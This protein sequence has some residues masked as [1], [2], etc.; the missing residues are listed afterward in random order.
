MKR[1]IPLIFPLFLLLF[2]EVS[3][4]NSWVSNSMSAPATSVISKTYSLIVN[5]YPEPEVGGAFIPKVVRS[6]YRLSAG[7]IIGMILGTTFAFIN[8]SSKITNR[9]INPTLSFLAPIPLVIWIP[10]CLM[11]FDNGNLYNIG[12]VSISSFFLF[13]TSLYSSYS[14]VQNSYLELGSIYEKSRW[15]K[16]KNIMFPSGLES[17]F[18]SIRLSIAIGWIAIYMT[19]YGSTTDKSMGLGYYIG[20]NRQIGKVEEQFAG[21]IVLG[22]LSFAMDKFIQLG[23]DHFLR[24]Q[25]RKQE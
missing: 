6:L 18:T 2:W 12:L 16:F 24:W 5:N 7:I 11:I 20:Y 10:F 17:F 8:V 23:Q 1:I 14:S 13:Y 9:L 21:V 4:S 15:E 3:F 25:E 22:V 19:E